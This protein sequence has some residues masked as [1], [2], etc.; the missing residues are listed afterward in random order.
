MNTFEEDKTLYKC[1]KLLRDSVH[2]LIVLYY[3][4]KKIN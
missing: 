2:C 4:K 1:E 3:T